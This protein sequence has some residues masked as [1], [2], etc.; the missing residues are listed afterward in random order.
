MNSYWK[1]HYDLISEQFPVSLLKQVGK[2]VNGQEISETQVKLITESIVNG[3]KLAAEDSIFDLCCGNGVITKQLASSVKDI[4]G[5]DFSTRLI[6]CARL[7]NSAN[8]IAYLNC[9][10]MDLD[11]KYF[12]GLKKI[13][14][15]EALQH[16]T[17]KE[18]IALLEVFDCLQSGALLFFGSIPNK[19]KLKTYYNTPE[20]YAY[21]KKSEAEGKPHMGRWW[22]MSEI[23]QIAS[24]YGYK[25]NILRQNPELYTAYYRFDVLLKKCP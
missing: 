5:V 15:Y 12:S 8:N 6:N 23:E 7:Y 18:V 20:K 2:T 4:V 14:M 11:P 22:L 21:Y 13:L 10:I 25:A 1:E 17:S 24:N 19:N 16:F 3:L 9:N